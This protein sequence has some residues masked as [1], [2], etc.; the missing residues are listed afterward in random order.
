M[1]TSQMAELEELRM[2]VL[3]AE[4][5]MEST[6]AE[7]MAERLTIAGREWQGA[8]VGDIRRCH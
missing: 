3:I 6:S 4:Q 5:R 8:S 7:S 2:R 1:L